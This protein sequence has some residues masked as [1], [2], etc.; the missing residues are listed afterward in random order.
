METRNFVAYWQNITPETK[1][2]W[3]EDLVEVMPR[4][5]SQW[6]WSLSSLLVDSMLDMTIGNIYDKTLKYIYYL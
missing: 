3:I 5:A 1:L 6:G 2:R 4:L